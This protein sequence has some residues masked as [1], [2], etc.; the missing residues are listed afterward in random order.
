MARHLD[1][2]LLIAYTARDSGAVGTYGNIPITINES[3][4]NG[5]QYITD[6]GDPIEAIIIKTHRNW[7]YP[8]GLIYFN[9]TAQN[10]WIY[11]D[12]SR[13]LYDAHRQKFLITANQFSRPHPGPNPCCTVVGDTLVR[14][15][16]ESGTAVFIQMFHTGNEQKIAQIHPR[17]VGLK[18][19]NSDNLNRIKILQS[20]QKQSFIIRID[21]REYFQVYICPKK[22]IKLPWKFKGAYWVVTSCGGQLIM[23]EDG[24]AKTRSHT[25]FICDDIPKKASINSIAGNNVLYCMD[26][27]DMHYDM[28]TRTI[29]G[30]ELPKN[31]CHVILLPPTREQKKEMEDTIWKMLSELIY[32]REVCGIIASFI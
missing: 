1:H 24:F 5:K 29:T 30:V 14:I 8:L 28:C 25:S 6:A 2:T 32:V 23:H 13:A 31:A 16:A 19:I 15:H 7:I 17:E 27:K 26:Q 18:E 20:D 4:R 21:D 22:I 9:E 11:S 10:F 12:F 3:L